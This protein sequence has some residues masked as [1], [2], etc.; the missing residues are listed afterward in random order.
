MAK[1]NL[2]PLI[3]KRN[4]AQD[5]L[6]KHQPELCHFAC[7]SLSFSYRLCLK[8]RLRLELLKAVSRKLIKVVCRKLIKAVCGKVLKVVFRGQQGRHESR[9]LQPDSCANN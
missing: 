9:R 3:I 6:P 8:V 7:V 4:P 2:S 1:D 5:H